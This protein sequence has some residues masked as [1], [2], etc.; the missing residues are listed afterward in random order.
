METRIAD[1]ENF[2]IYYYD[3]K[4][5]LK[6]HVYRRSVEAFQAGDTAR[7]GIQTREELE[8]RRQAAREALL[9]GIGGLPAYDGPLHAEIVGEVRLKGMRIEK[10]VFESR[11]NT[12]VTASMYIP[13]GL[14]RPSAAV[15]FVCGHFEDGRLNPNYQAVCRTIAAAGLLVFAIDP[16]GQGERSSYYDPETGSM[17]ISRS[18]SDHEQAGAQCWPLGDGLARY[19]LHDIVR[20]VDYLS[21]HPDVD[22]QR[23]GITGNSG[24]G[25]QTAMAMLAEPR[26]AAAAPA[27]FLMN[28]ESYLFAGQAQ[29]AEQIWPGMSA[30]GF[31]HEDVLI[32]MAP[33]PVLVLA[34]DY[35]YFPIEGTRRTV[36]R[37]KRFWEMYGAPE[38]LV[39]FEDRSVHRYSERMAGAAAAFF[40]EHLLDVKEGDSERG[41]AALLSAR[42]ADYC[43]ALELLKAEDLQCTST[44]QIRGCYDGERGPCEENADRVR[45][46]ARLR[47][48]L[49]DEERKRRATEWLEKIV[50]ARRMDVPMNP[51]QVSLGV[52]EGLKA[53]SWLWWS[54]EGLFNHAFVFRAET[55][56]NGRTPVVI[57]VWERGT[58]RLGERL[59]W[60]KE[61]AASGKAVMVLDV[62]GEGVLTPNAINPLGVY[63]RFGTIHKLA[64][65]LFFIGDSLAAIRVFDVLRAVEMAMLPEHIDAKSVEVHGE[66]KFN[67][68]VKLA[69]ALDKEGAVDKWGVGSGMQSIALWY[70]ERHYDGYDTLGTVLPGM[71][72]YFDLPELAAWR[73]RNGRSK[74]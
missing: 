28:R 32:A 53:E 74:A 70:D 13:D 1:L 56:E 51:R 36:E 65:D 72:R 31:D 12:H 47:S 16:I 57:A 73:A 33:K 23:I 40:V 34:A 69:E 9:E 52:V 5:Q 24:G 7:D 59:N 10:I 64:T 4:D 8:R 44:G 38:R 50:L 19:F 61:I 11:P 2:T 25:L 60:I 35:D 63:D 54:Q 48:E 49:P 26:L 30:N 67:L 68:Y 58:R 20:G 41:A 55:F 27:T 66:G 45:E 29:D 39:L 6:Q 71:L 42:L 43:S 62:T 15:L 46:L 3:V 17:A 37:T 21:S 18:V 14:S 22:P